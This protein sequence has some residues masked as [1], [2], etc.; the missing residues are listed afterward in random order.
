M[1]Q[2]KNNKAAGMTIDYSNGK[3]ISR[4]ELL[5]GV[6]IAI[7]DDDID[8]LKKHPIFNHHLEEG[9]LVVLTK[10]PTA[11]GELEGFK[12]TENKATDEPIAI[13]NTKVSKVA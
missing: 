1:A 11:K 10:E 9:T 5:P 7:P 13:V 2:I 3:G 8:H 6:N 12:V 4:I